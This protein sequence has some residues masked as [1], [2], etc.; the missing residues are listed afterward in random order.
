[1][2]V[3]LVKRLFKEIP[4]ITALLVKLN[5]KQNSIATTTLLSSSS[6]NSKSSV[7]ARNFYF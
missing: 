2:Y 6:V 3:K 4:S 7:K 1:M 5:G